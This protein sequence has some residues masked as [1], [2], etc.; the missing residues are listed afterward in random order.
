VGKSSINKHAKAR[1][2]LKEEAVTV[3][4]AADHLCEA[5]KKH[6]DAIR[7]AC[8]FWEVSDLLTCLSVFAEWVCAADVGTENTALEIGI[9]LRRLVADKCIARWGAKDEERFRDLD[10]ALH[11]LHL[12][13]HAAPGIVTR[14]VTA[15]GLRLQQ[16]IA[17]ARSPDRM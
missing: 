12:T 8:E 5:R 2:L 9:S 3:L 15:A 17:V 1:R 13:L 16:E 4:T 11:H 10:Y 7:F 14:E 6:Q